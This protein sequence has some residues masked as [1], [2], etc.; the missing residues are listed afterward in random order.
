MRLARSSS[1]QLNGQQR[2]A[3]D[4]SATDNSAAQRT[5]AQREEECRRE[6]LTALRVRAGYSPLARW[7]KPA[8][9][10]LGGETVR[11]KGESGCLWAIY[12]V[13][14]EGLL[15]CQAALRQRLVSRRYPS[16]ET[17]SPFV[18]L[19]A[20]SPVHPRNECT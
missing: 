3:T 11:D 8:A 17:G 4:N 16:T 6:P 12:H 9:G 13:K 19:R 18:R 20:A 15:I 10:I 5:A 1:S 2:S 14:H 7:R